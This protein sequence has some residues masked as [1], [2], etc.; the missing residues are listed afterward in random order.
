M[1]VTT[2]TLLI[3]VQAAFLVLGAVI[4]KA[5]RGVLEH[6]KEFIAHYKQDTA[7][8]EFEL[9]Q[10][11]VVLDTI[12]LIHERQIEMAEELKRLREIGRAH[13]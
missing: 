7:K 3:L 9:R 6:I 8:R 2:A 13:V 12:V 4:V 1:T 11:E 10:R 5:L